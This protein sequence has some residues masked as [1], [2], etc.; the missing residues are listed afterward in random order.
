MSGTSVDGIDTAIVKITEEQNDIALDLVHFDTIPYEQEVKEEILKLCD[1]NTARVENLS[2][3]NML[4]G[5]LYA[6]AVNQVLQDTELD[7]KDISLISSHGQTIFH[8]PTA[9]TFS[10]H[11]VASTLQIGDIAVIA[12]KT[13]IT[14]V[15]DFRTRDMAAGGQ[16]APLVPYADYLLF[17]KKDF[18]RVL[19]NI[20]GISNITVLPKDGDE[21]NV[22]AYDTGPGN[23]II[24]YFAE[25]I[26]GG[27]LSYDHDGLLAA[28]GKV[29]MEWLDNL[30]QHPY[31]TQTPP[32]STGREMFG[33]DYAKALWEQAEQRSIPYEDRIATITA[34]TAST[35]TAEIIRYITETSIKEV[36]ISGGGSNN[37][38]LM[39]YITNYLPSNVMVKGTH[40]YGINPDAKEAMIFALL[41]YQCLKKRTN[42]LPAA[43]GSKRNV[44]MGKIAW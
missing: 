5:S 8:Q 38:T 27:N 31:F 29:Q 18:G 34:L 39:K 23:M 10:G 25:K 3:M 2:N 4:L 30:V 36:L 7:H 24:D 16:G 41:G 37:P 28:N 9:I 42:N 22:L 40:D 11:S 43:T 26:T 17:Q 1:P 15:G 19:V 21:S 6:D 35:L 14:T 13:G 20:G 33:R 12:E 44:V 32:K